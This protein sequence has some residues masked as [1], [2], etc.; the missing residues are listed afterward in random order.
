MKRTC[1]ERC[2]RF[3]C[4]ALCRSRQKRLLSVFCFRSEGGQTFAA[5][6]NQMGTATRSDA[7]T[8]KLRKYRIFVTIRR[9]FERPEG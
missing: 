3:F 7:V 2:V 8:K 4:G 5:M 9:R 6:E 1:R